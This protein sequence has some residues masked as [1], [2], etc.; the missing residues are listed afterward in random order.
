MHKVFKC[1]DISIRHIYIS[2][3]V[4]FD[5]SIFPFVSLH[6]IAG[7]QYHSDVLLTPPLASGDNNFTDAANTITLPTLPLYDSCVQV[8]MATTAGPELGLLPG[9]NSQPDTVSDPSVLNPSVTSSLRNVDL[10]LPHNTPTQ[11][12]IGSSGS[13]GAP[14]L[15]SPALTWQPTPAPFATSNQ[16]SCT[17]T[18]T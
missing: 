5:E 18:P 1:L 4:I 14:H 12:M 10:T 11:P 2:R 3:D 15:V 9:V 6:S 17:C 7:A 8:L 13:S 16:V